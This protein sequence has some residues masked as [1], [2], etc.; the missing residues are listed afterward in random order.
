MSLS[1]ESLDFKR[2]QRYVEGFVIPVNHSESYPQIEK[3]WNS[4]ESSQDPK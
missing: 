3:F 4:G 2:L 1:L